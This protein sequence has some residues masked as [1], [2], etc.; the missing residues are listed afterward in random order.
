MSNIKKDHQSFTKKEIEYL[1]KLRIIKKNLVHVHGFPKNTAKIDILH[2]KEYFGQYGAIIKF[3]MS[4]KINPDNKKVYSAYITYLN[5]TEAACAILCVD[6]LLIEGKIIRAFFGTTKYCNY[7]LNNQICPNLDKCIFLHQLKDEKDIIIDD[8][9]IFTYDD[10]IYLAKKIIQYSN[11]K[12]KDSFLK[13]QKPKKIIFPFFDFIYL[14]E[15]EKEHYFNTGNISYVKTESKFQKD[16]LYNNFNDSKSETNYINNYFN[17]II[18]LSNKLNLNPICLKDN[19][20]NI[21]ANNILHIRKYVDITNNFFEPKEFH[22]YID[23]SIKHI[24]AVKPFYSNLKNYPY[25]KLEF[26]FFIKDLEKKGKNFYELFDGCFDC[27][28]D[29]I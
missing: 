9:I 8:N 10:H 27:L 24:L 12:I 19:N 4:Y 7:F 16:N 14:T 15:E 23:D 22:K 25:K 18:N 13:M 20:N 29:V 2:S 1:T 28:K 21:N 6:S 11:P 17:I 3:C 5:E 26:E